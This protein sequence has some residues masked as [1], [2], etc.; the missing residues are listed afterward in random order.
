MQGYYGRVNTTS[1]SLHSV[2]KHHPETSAAN[3]QNRTNPTTFKRKEQVVMA[4]KKLTIK[5]FYHVAVCDANHCVFSLSPNH[6]ALFA[7]V[8]QEA[9]DE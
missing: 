5:V 3:T 6:L 1:L 8:M 4:I 2:K 9:D 7:T